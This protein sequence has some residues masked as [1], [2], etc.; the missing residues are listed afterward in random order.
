MKPI[1]T[2]LASREEFGGDLPLL[3]M[4]A[5]S[6]VRLRP[7]GEGRAASE[8]T[9]NYR[10]V[11]KGDLVVNRLVARDGAYGVST[12]DGIISPA[13]WVL[14]P[15][16]DMDALWL[17]FVL[18][19]AP[20]RTE[21]ARLSKDMPPAQFDLPWDQFKGLRIP[22]PPILL[23][24]RISDFLDRETKRIDDLVWAKRR[25]IKILN[26]RWIALL[27]QELLGGVTPDSEL[28][29]G[30]WLKSSD[31]EWEIVPLRRLVTGVVNGSWGEEAG[32]LERDVLC[33]RAADFNFSILE[34]R[35]AVLRSY[36]SS[37]LVS[38][39]IGPG[40]LLMEKSGGG[41][42]MPV[43][44]VVQWRGDS[45]AIPT[46]FAAKL[47]I[48]DRATADYVLLL[49]RALYACGFNYRW[50]KQT[51][52]IQNLDTGGLLSERVPVPNRSLQASLVR[53]LQAELSRTSEAMGKLENQVRLLEERRQSLITAAVT[54]QLEI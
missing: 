53:F 32:A 41:D 31:P 49:M 28:G 7:E 35:D 2:L 13:Y 46:N 8:D 9:S 33:V 1:W 14:K 21:I 40:D 29:E 47:N 16:D 17:E 37:D 42:E 48:S 38:R 45:A 44:R 51:T 52:G 27:V 20:Y 5:Q 24:S 39:S 19:S 18:K 6:G 25:Q 3:S 10:I 4:S 23:Q 15:C 11:R 36:R 34:A 54:G 12:F 26:E 22:C 30:M 43:G 50:I